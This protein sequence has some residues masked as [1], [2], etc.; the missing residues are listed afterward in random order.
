MVDVNERI[1]AG[2]LLVFQATEDG[3]AA[4]WR[5][6]LFGMSAQRL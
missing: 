1:E 6:P 3:I 4:I 2:D 5:T